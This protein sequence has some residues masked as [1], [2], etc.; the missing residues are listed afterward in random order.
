MHD[1]ENRHRRG[2]LTFVPVDIHTEERRKTVHTQSERSFAVRP[3][4]YTGQVFKY[5]IH[6]QD[7]YIEKVSVTVPLKSQVHIKYSTKMK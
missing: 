4:Q 5:S 1:C 3:P 6:F 7:A 2:A